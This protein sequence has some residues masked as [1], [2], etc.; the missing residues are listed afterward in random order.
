M[1]ELDSAIIRE[2]QA[3]ARQSNRELARTLG[4][5]ASTCLERVRA[6][7]RRG[8]IRGYHA[9]IDLGAL[10]REVQALVSVQIRPLSRAV[11][12]AFKDT[13]GRMPEVLT[14]FVLAGGDDFVL[15]VAVPNLD[16]LHAFLVDQLSNRR[17]VVGFRTSVIYQRQHNTVLAPFS[18]G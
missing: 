14:A 18:D 3:N 13:V 17:E 11:I 7:T 6:L 1:D 16:H 9:D 12:D 5:A 8:V 4:I 2:L 10:N 15:H